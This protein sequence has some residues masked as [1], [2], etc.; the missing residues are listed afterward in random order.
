LRPREWQVLWCL[1][2]GMRNHDI[3]RQMS[4]SQNTVEKHI[5]SVLQKLGLSSRTMLLAYILANHLDVLRQLTESEN[6]FLTWTHDATGP[7]G[8][9]AEK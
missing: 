6:P 7:S 2:A 4:L 3:A 1:M 5:S 8:A 9:V